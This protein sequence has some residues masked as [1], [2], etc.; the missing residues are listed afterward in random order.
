MD[1]F[2]PHGRGLGGREAGE[3]GRK[4]RSSEALFL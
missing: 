2:S 4:E 3:C 1:V